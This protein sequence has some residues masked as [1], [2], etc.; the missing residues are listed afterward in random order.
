MSKQRTIEQLHETIK[1]LYNSNGYDKVTA[2]RIKKAWGLINDFVLD[3]KDAPG[4]VAVPR[5]DLEVIQ[6][7][8]CQHYDVDPVAL[9][10]NY[11]WGN[12]ILIMQQII[13]L[14]RKHLRM[15]YESLGNYFAHR[16]H[17]TAISSYRIIQN[18]IKTY[19]GFAE[20]IENFEDILENVKRTR[21]YHRVEIRNT[22]KT[23]CV[24]LNKMLKTKL[25]DKQ[26]HYLYWKYS[27][28]S[29]NRLDLM[30]WVLNYCKKR[31]V[32][33]LKKSYLCNHN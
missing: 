23:F 28:E 9:Q 15:T 3:L 11:R 33:Q 8:V 20:H 6:R 31:T 10:S 16:D 26:Y 24:T 4:N 12:Q 1:L 18:N 21:S 13:Y 32:I 14:S 5:L 29:A 30:Q 27:G 19:N 25:T 7:I 17:S 2:E 22:F